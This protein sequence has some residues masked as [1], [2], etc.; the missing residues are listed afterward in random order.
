MVEAPELLTQLLDGSPSHSAVGGKDGECLGEGGLS[1]PRPKPESRQGETWKRVL[2][3]QE[4]LGCSKTLT[5]ESYLINPIKIYL[6]LLKSPGQSGSP[7]QHVASGICT[8]EE[9]AGG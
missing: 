9:R 2:F 5:P 3:G 8:A 4:K 7:V 1:E 6:G